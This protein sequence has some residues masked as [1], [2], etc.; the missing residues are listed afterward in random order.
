MQSP[1]IHSG[2]GF[3][4][5]PCDL[6][7]WLP[8]SLPEPDFP[9]AL[10]SLFSE[11]W[12]PWWDQRSLQSWTAVAHASFL[13]SLKSHSRNVDVCHCHQYTCFNPCSLMPIHEASSHHL[14]LSGSHLHHPSPHSQ[15]LKDLWT[16]K[17]TQTNHFFSSLPSSRLLGTRCLLP[18]LLPWRVPGP[19]RRGRWSAAAHSLEIQPVMRH[20]GGPEPELLLDS[21]THQPPVP[22]MAPPLFASSEDGG[23]DLFFYMFWEYNYSCYIDRAKHGLRFDLICTG[24]KSLGIIR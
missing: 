20:K 4:S 9:F 16:Q 13:P 21:E 12:K 23:S 17:K 7:S 5:Q 22:G 8:W 18:S 14:S 19:H 10:T 11:P 6:P 1:A 3:H 15:A 2:A 24:F